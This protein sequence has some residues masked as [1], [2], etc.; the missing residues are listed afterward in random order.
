MEFAANRQLSIALNLFL[1]QR[2][3]R[4]GANAAFLLFS[5]S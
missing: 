5:I 1:A 3:L 2:F 4:P